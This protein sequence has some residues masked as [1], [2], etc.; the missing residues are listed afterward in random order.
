MNRTK[1]LWVGLGGSLALVGIVTGATLG[2]TTLSG[3]TFEDSEPKPAQGLDSEN[4]GIDQVGSAAQT[5]RYPGFSF[6]VEA[7]GVDQALEAVGKAKIE[8]ALLEVMQHP[9]W[10]LLR[11]GSPPPLVDTGCPSDPL[12]AR[13]GVNWQGEHVTAFGNISQYN[14][15][16]P[17]FYWTFIFVMPADQIDQLLG[18]APVRVAPQEYR[19]DGGDSMSLETTAIFFSPEELDDAPFLVQQLL[20]A[21]GLEPVFP[22]SQY[23]DRS[24]R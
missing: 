5:E 11:P 23:P 1:R 15:D 21:V 2:I 24:Q 14:V 6:C 12:I 19:W 17:S 16:A 10:N 4:L 9:Y 18:Q 20:V 7:M 22:E 3:T 8:A 13:P